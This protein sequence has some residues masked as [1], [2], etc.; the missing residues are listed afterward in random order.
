MTL[1]IV[2]WAVCLAAAVLAQGCTGDGV[3]TQPSAIQRG[4]PPA[5]SEVAAKYNERVGRMD[6]LWAR[7]VIRVSYRDKDGAERHDQLEGHL[8][9]L[10]PDRLLLTFDKVGNTYAALGSNEAKYWWIEKT[11]GAKAYVGAH[12]EADPALI[13]QL[14]LPVHPLNFIELLGITPLPESA[15]GDMKVSWSPDGR[16]L[17]V[18]APGR[19]APRRLWLDPDRYVPTRVEILEPDG[20]VAIGADLG[21]F[22]Q[23][24]DVKVQTPVAHWSPIIPTELEAVQERDHL[25]VRITLFAPETAGSKPK[26]SAFDL[27]HLLQTFDVKEVVD[28]N[29]QPVRPAP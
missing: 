17:V 26:A 5:Y 12:G 29:Q 22:A 28:L 4:A 11:D 8:Q 1:R 19:M 14:G 10:R 18:V 13:K 15:A 7:T 20:S 3:H 6:R 27:D 16:S 23:Y 2:G 21:T 9:Y 24:Q 25:R